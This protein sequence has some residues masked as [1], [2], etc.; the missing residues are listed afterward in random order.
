M[1]NWRLGAVSL[2]VG[3]LLACGIIYSLAWGNGLGDC[4]VTTA[5]HDNSIRLL[6]AAVAIAIVDLVLCAA[7]WRP[8]RATGRRWIFPTGV[9]TAVLGAS[10]VVLLAGFN[11]RGC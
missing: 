3:L 1:L 5:P 10:G 8:L 2:A 6:Q 4:N 11:F 9:A 7:I